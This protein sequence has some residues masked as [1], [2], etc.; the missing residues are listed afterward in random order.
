[1][2]WIA[3]LW[4]HDYRVG[5]LAAGWLS[6]TTYAKYDRVKYQFSIYESLASGN[7]NNLPTD[8]THWMLVQSNFIGVA[9]RILYNGITLTLTYALNKRFG[10]IFRQPN[11]VSDIYIGNN[12]PPLAPFIFGG[13]EAN[14]S[15]F[16]S[17]FS[18]EFFINSYDFSA[19]YNFNINVPLA[20][21]NALDPLPANR[22]KIFRSFVNSI[23]P[24][25]ITYK[26]VTY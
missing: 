22:D 26:I 14:S 3:N 7:L 21:Y 25:G 24:A 20:V 17:Q 11:N 15:S 9:E 6:T 8:Q 19:N 23:I 4:L 10:T 5:S 12:T 16:F 2:Q 18:T 13:A 1:M